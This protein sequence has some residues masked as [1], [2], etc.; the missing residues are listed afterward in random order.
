[1]KERGTLIHYSDFI[2]QIVQD[3]ISNT[4]L[5]M[6]DEMWGGDAGEMAS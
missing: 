1:M 5:I 2:A 6:D 4:K 3:Q